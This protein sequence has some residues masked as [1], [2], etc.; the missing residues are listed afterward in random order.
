[1]FLLFFSCVARPLSTLRLLSGGSR[2]RRTRTLQLSTHE[3]LSFHD[4]CHV[5][6]V[7]LLINFDLGLP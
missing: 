5:Y 7:F 2:V 1:M 6:A 3:L 4:D